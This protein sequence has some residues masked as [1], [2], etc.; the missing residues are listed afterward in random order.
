MFTLLKVE[1]YKLK[2][3]KILL[4][5]TIFTFLALYQGWDSAKSGHAEGEGNVFKDF[6]F[7]GTATVYSWII[8]PLIITLVLV[9]MSRMEHS[10][11]SWKYYL[12]LPVD[13]VKVYL[14]KLVIGGG[15]IFYSLVL[16]FVGIILAANFLGLEA[17]PLLWLAKRFALLL[18][19]SFAIIGIVFYLSYRFTHFAVPIAIGAGL[20]FPSMFVANSEKYW[21]F[22][23]WDYP[24]IA[25]MTNVFEVGGKNTSMLV[26][27][28]SIFLFAIIIGL[29]RF[30]AKDVL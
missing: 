9:M 27:S 19:S 5:T 24:I 10:N 4:T 29:L 16:L 15:I 23:P 1:L 18:L 8:F 12:T 30:R 14:A 2:R 17:V 28:I 25:S 7:Q 3:S 11:N 26:I 13:R 6:L 22:Y 20:A 21:I